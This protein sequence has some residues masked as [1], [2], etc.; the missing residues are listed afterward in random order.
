M[1]KTDSF[2]Q[3]M[4]A[5]MAV[6][7][8]MYEGDSLPERLAA[9]GLAS[10]SGGADQLDGEEEDPRPPKAGAAWRAV[11]DSKE[12]E[13]P[14]SSTSHSLTETLE[15]MEETQRVG[16]GLHGTRAM[17]TPVDTHGPGADTYG[18]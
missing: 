1:L 4:E 2:W 10:S 14:A 15:A 7:T 12:P 17:G 6:H 9:I 18:C 5:T 11:E 8:L 3:D 13:L 16:P